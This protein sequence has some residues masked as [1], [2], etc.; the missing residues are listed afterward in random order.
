V[1]ALEGSS[2]ASTAMGVRH[3]GA[4]H[5]CISCRAA[6]AAAAARLSHLCHF[7]L[8]PIY[9]PICEHYCARQLTSQHLG[10]CCSCL[11]GQSLQLYLF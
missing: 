8:L 7:V 1:S 2:M 6:A 3:W 5:C 11:F 4:R 10:N 9:L